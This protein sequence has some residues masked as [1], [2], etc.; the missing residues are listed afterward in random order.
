TTGY[1]IHPALLDAAL[2]LALV[3][4]AGAGSAETGQLR[5]PFAFSGVT[6]H[7]TGATSLRVQLTHTGDDSATLTA[8]DPDGHPVISIDTIT[9]RPLPTGQLTAVGS[10]HGRGV[11]HPVWQPVHHAESSGT[12]GRWA[13]LGTDSL[14]LT[15]ALSAAGI[16]AEGHADADDLG[17]ALDAGGPAPDVLALPYA[18]DTDATGALRRMLDVLQRCLGDERLADTRL[19]LLTRHAVS[20]STDQ[21]THDLAAAAVHGL[22]H[23]AANEHPGRISLLDLDTHTT[24]AHL[25]TAART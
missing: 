10:A 1:G 15:E 25:A 14:G 22:A 12:A 20:A 23:T 7:A 9:L 3:D 11:H 19:L 13:V 4:S 18:D 21:D 24:P 8:T 16:K 6:L 2:H 17:A 5:L